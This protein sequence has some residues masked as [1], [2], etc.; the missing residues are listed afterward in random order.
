VH[1]LAPGLLD[2]ALRATGLAH[3]LRGLEGGLD[4][5]HLARLLCSRLFLERSSA[6]DVAAALR[7]TVAASR[8]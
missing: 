4:P 6:G 3:R 5:R 7:E 8:G 2:A 1:G